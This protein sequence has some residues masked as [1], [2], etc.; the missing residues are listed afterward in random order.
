MF[1][2][3]YSVLVTFKNNTASIFDGST[4]FIESDRRV[5]LGPVPNFTVAPYQQVTLESPGFLFDGRDQMLT[6][7]GYGQISTARMIS[8]STYRVY[9]SRGMLR[10]PSAPSPVQVAPVSGPTRRLNVGAIRLIM[11]NGQPVLPGQMLPSGYSGQGYIVQANIANGSPLPLPGAVWG[12]LDGDRLLYAERLSMNPGGSLQASSAPIVYDG[13]ARTLTVFASGNCIAGELHGASVRTA[14]DVSMNHVLVQ[15]APA[16]GRVGI[17]EAPMPPASLSIGGRQSFTQT[18]DTCVQITGVPTDACPGP[19]YFS[20]AVTNRCTDRRFV[21]V[22]TLR[23]AWGQCVANL[24][25]P[26][27]S[28]NGPSCGQPVTSGYRVR[29]AA[30][31]VQ[32]GVLSY[33]LQPLLYGP[34]MESRP[35]WPR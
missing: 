23:D 19:W 13:T 27:A 16:P 28:M 2:Q 8:G 1:G 14:A 26:G 3:P 32:N 18:V 4:W 25:A 34:S 31:V 30:P 6:I 11:A 33:P 20:L 24:V 5:R 22:C 7:T 12:V 29:S 21:E 35:G 15:M 9:P 10:L 17:P